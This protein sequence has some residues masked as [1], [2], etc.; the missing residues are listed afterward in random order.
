M[1]EDIRR[2]LLGAL[3]DAAPGWMS[4][5]E[6]ARRLGLSRT[7]VWKHVRALRRLGYAVEAR[8]R[9]GYRLAGAPDLP[10]A[11]EVAPLLTTRRIG[12]PYHF[13]LSVDSTNLELR[14]LAEA[15]APEGTVVVADEQTAGRGRRGRSWLS[16]PGSGVWMSVLLHPTVPPAQAGLLT[17]MSAVAVREAVRRETGLAA[18]IKWPNDLLVGERKLC[19]I[20]LELAADQEALRHVIVGIGINVR[21]PAGGFPP[22]VAAA[23]TSLEEASGRPCRR[24]RLVAAICA[25]LET[26][27]E[28]A[29]AGAAADV[30][31][32]WRRG[33]DWLGSPVTVVRPDGDLRGTAEDV[34]PDGGLIVRD[35]T[36]RRHTVYAGDVSLR[37]APRG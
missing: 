10:L 35:E 7:A 36:G 9:L 21:P 29:L 8:T 37:F 33:A 14:R 3:H 30:L 26:W 1:A 15:G 32:A 34:A 28:R 4:G 17:L 24:A 18:R 6:L 13:L 5:A 2:R 11:A 23:A 27:Y 16:S 20:L 19:G 31:D 25:Q 12:R 22:D